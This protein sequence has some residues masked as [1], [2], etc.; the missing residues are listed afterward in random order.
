MRI[1]TRDGLSF[2]RWVK[3][4]GAISPRFANRI[5]RRNRQR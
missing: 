2:A 1:L 5:I 4:V 3:W